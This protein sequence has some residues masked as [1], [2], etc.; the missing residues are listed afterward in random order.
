MS[1]S[2][3]SA[4]LTILAMDT[5]GRACSAALLRDGQIRARRFE[6]ME[7]GQSERLV[8]MLLEVLADGGCGFDA[9]DAIAVTVGPGAFTGVR[10][11]LATARGLALARDLPLIGVTCFEAVAEAAP[12][13]HSDGRHLAVLLDA[14]RRDLFVQVFGA[15]GKP[16]APAR[17]LLPEQ[18]DAELPVGA[19]LLAGDATQA[20][21][22]SLVAAGRDVRVVAEAVA[23]DADKVALSAVRQ[24]L[25]TAGSPPPRPLYLRPPDV[26]PPRR[27]RVSGCH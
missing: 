4:S 17:S 1:L 9:L 16:L 24:G 20:A 2:R 23:V 19:L 13:S 5:A 22:D 14:K 26:T 7:R 6:A 11:G 12:A 25:P 8:P 18:L 27:D 10:I 15:A 21:Y 3:D